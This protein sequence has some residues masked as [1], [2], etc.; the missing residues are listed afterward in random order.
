METCHVP[1]AHLHAETYIVLVRV[2]GV[3]KSKKQQLI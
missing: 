2:A 1:V 3:S